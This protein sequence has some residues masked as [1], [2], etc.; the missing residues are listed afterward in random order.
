MW[1][2]DTGDEEKINAIEQTRSRRASFLKQGDGDG[3][4]GG[5]GT[6]LNERLQTIEQQQELILQLLRAQAALAP[7]T[8]LPSLAHAE[9]N[10]QCSRVA[11]PACATP[12]GGGAD[13]VLP[14]IQHEQTPLAQPLLAMP[15]AAAADRRDTASDRSGPGAA[16]ASSCQLFEP[17]PS[18]AADLE[19]PPRASVVRSPFRMF[20]GAKNDRRTSTGSCDPM[21]APQPA[22]LLKRLST[23]ANDEGKLEI[24]RGS[25]ETDDSVLWSQ[26]ESQWQDLGQL[27]EEDPYLDQL[28]EKLRQQQVHSAKRHKM[29]RDGTGVR[30]VKKGARQRTSW[31]KRCLALLLPV[32]DHEGNFRR[33]WDLVL[34]FLVLILAV[35]VPL[36]ISFE[37]DMLASEAKRFWEVF[38]LLMDVFFM[39]DILINLRTSFSN[40][41]VTIISTREMASSYFRGFFVI[42]LIGAIPF[43]AFVGSGAN[44]IKIVRMMRLLKLARLLRAASFFQALEHYTQFNP[45]VLRLIGLTMVAA[46][47]CHWAGCAWW[48]IGEPTAGEDDWSP[49]RELVDDPSFAT[50]YFYSFFWGVSIVSGVTAVDVMPETLPQIIST[51]VLLVLSVLVTATAVSSATSTLSNMD[52]TAELQRRQLDMINQFMRY[53][54]VP[55]DLRRR[56]NDFYEYLWSSVQSIKYAEVVKELPP[57]LQLQLLLAL[58]MRLLTQVPIFKFCDT[59]CIIAMTQKMQPVIYLPREF[60]LRQGSN[61]RAMYFINRGTCEILKRRGIENYLT[62]AVL[63]N[64]DFFG[65]TSLIFGRPVDASV[66]AV[67]YCDISVLPYHSF[68]QIMRQFPDLAKMVVSVAK[69]LRERSGDK[70]GG[71]PSISSVVTSAK[72]IKKANSFI[73]KLESRTN[74]IETSVKEGVSGRLDRAAEKCPAMR[75]L[76][77][78]AGG[79]RGSAG[80]RYSQVARRRDTTL[81]R[82]QGGAQP[83]RDGSFND[84]TRRSDGD[85]RRSS[86]VNG[87]KRRSVAPAPEGGGG[88]GGSGGGSGGGA[89]GGGGGAVRQGLTLCAAMAASAPLVLSE[90]DADMMQSVAEEDEAEMTKEAAG[91]SGTST[92]AAAATDGDD[93][94]DAAGGASVECRRA[95]KTPSPPSGS[96]EKR[97]SISSR[98][99]SSHN[100]KGVLAA[101]AREEEAKQ[102]ELASDEVLDDEDRETDLLFSISYDPHED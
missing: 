39:L 18:S 91:R 45:G 101:I 30:G 70:G 77:S 11:P 86:T 94:T 56:I 93:A 90:D 7:P 40:E 59:R 68:Q 33:I 47:V 9:P 24:E 99:K 64:S 4:G 10:G 73:A 85:G 6:A 95:S 72:A 22:A 19:Q 98:R 63:G 66:R 3:G 27:L 97:R 25:Y 29:A 26:H 71:R 43:Q 23:A 35:V 75:R 89:V 102:A 84:G 36:Q 15:P 79:A 20:D 34:M 92:D 48:L 49:T 62:V 1:Q 37:R 54:N 58:N 13:P 67:T 76:S 61:G 65:E 42:D 82:R 31:K 8:V 38:N 41:G 14:A 88:G 80:K 28:I 16:L 69:K 83:A 78:L 21:E 17:T 87:G 55:N 52:A 60:I 12:G 53:K 96:F 32:F 50:K 57:A 5:D 46:M 51:T 100:D 44:A 74:R 81:A 2:A